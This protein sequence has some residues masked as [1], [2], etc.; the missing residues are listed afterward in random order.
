[1]KK[2]LDLSPQTIKENISKL[3]KFMSEKG[4][5]GFYI[6]SFDPYL[7]EYVPLEDC[8]RFYF[9]GFTGSVA[10]VLIPAKGKARIYVDGRYHEQVDLEVPADAVLAVKPAG[11]SNSQALVSDVRELGLKKIGIEADRTSLGF[12]KTLEGVC[13]TEGFYQNE[14]AQFVAF[15]A[16]P[17]PKEIQF[18]ARELRGRD[19][20]EKLHDVFQKE[21]HGMFLAALDGIAWL[22]N[23]RGYHLPHLSSFRAKALLTRQKVYVFVSPETPLSKEA[24]TIEGIEWM[25]IPQAQMAQELTR[26]Q[27]KLHLDEVVL[28]P[29]MLNCADFNMLLAVFGPDRLRE[30]AG[31][32]IEWMSIKEP[33]EIRAMEESFRRADKAIFETIKWVKE[34]TKN[35]KRTTELDLWKQTSEEY[36]KQ[37][38]VE[39]S[40]NTIAGVG[41]NGSIIHYGNPSDE[42]IIKADD[43]VLLDS[44]GY[45]ASGFATDCT[46]TFFA[47]FQ[48]QPKSDYKKIYT[49]VLKG[50]L[51]CQ[52]A[53]FT[54]GTKGNVLDGIARAPLMKHGYN[55]NHGTGHGVG[56]HVHEDGVRLSLISTL[57]MKAGQVVSIEPGIYVPGFGGVRLENIAVVEKHPEFK[58]YL[59]FRSLVFVG[60]DPNLIDGD[61]LN[62]EEKRQLVSYEKLCAERGTSLISL[63]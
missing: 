59:K 38:A 54:E 26:L 4:L 28:D 10:E 57:P 16:L 60:F 30:K 5:D 37:G 7:N 55:Y 40:F 51:A 9:T 49:L 21:S 43:M 11:L 32:L 56:V 29:S 31:G 25:R 1:M 47:S 19:T 44:G 3:Q 63:G 14:V 22:T 39:Q 34:N 13:E 35:G 20:L 6:S 23:C 48:G 8:H 17:A 12:L 15:A 41:P 27:N 33:T 46:R 36:R 42:V 24:Q 62:D 2:N 53:V 58:G 52:N 18:V 61:Y 50:V 45:F